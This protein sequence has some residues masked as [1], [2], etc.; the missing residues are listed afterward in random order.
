MATDSWN[1]KAKDGG[2]GGLLYESGNWGDLLKMLWLA[3]ILRWKTARCGDNVNYFDPFAGD[4]KYPLGR[5]TL[6]RF[7]QANLPGLDFIRSQFVEDGYWPSSASAA[8]LLIRGEAE[9]F[10]ADAGRRERWRHVAGATVLDGESGLWLLENR[11]PDTQA[12]WLLDPYDLLAE[13]RD[14]LPLIVAKARVSSTLVYIYNRAGRSPEAFREYRAFRNALDDLCGQA[15]KCLGRVAADAFLPRTHHEML[16]IPGQADAE[17]AEYPA[18]EREL[19]AVSAICAA[20]L[21]RAAAF[22]I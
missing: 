15:P 22:D 12:L 4:V 13:W 16:F 7:E 17:A 3:A 14:A 5:R 6:F 21:D 8:L 9:L 20:A 1:W 11:R 2:S 18:L 19:A 10:D